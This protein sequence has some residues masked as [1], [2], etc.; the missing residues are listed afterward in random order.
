VEALLLEGLE[1]HLQ[2]ALEVEDHQQ[3]A[4]EVE[5]HQQVVQEAEDHQLEVLVVEDHQQV[6]RVVVDHQLEV[7]VV[8]DPLQV[9]AREVV[10]V[11]RQERCNAVASV[12]VLMGQKTATATVTAPLDQLPAVDVVKASQESVLQAAAGSVQLKWLPFVLVVKAGLRQ[13]VVLVATDLLVVAA[14]VVLVET[15]PLVEADLVETVP[16]V[17]TV[18]L[19]EEVVQE[20][21]AHLVVAADLV[22]T[23]LLV[24]DLLEGCL[25]QCLVDQMG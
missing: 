3:E 11:V 9:Q 18:L 24:V 23:D 20:A 16:Q 15:V 4:Q 8:E 2:V 12:A 6:A 14:A 13:G 19:V 1:D 21:I 7:P 5:D 17:A 10:K 25:L 22:A